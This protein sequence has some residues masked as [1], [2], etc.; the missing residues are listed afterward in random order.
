MAYNLACNLQLPRILATRLMKGK[1]M[2]ER[3]TGL[4][5]AAAVGTGGR[6]CQ[7]Q[8]AC[9]KSSEVA[10]NLS[11]HNA[12]LAGWNTALANKSKQFDMRINHRANWQ[13]W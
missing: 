5:G 11:V 13:R 4:R 1:R 3:S 6:Q 12:W 7:R 10:F 9:K 8:E 2:R